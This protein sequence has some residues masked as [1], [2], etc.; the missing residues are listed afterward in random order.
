MERAVSPSTDVKFVS[1]VFYWMVVN[2]CWEERVNPPVYV[3]TQ[4]EMSFAL[5]GDPRV[6]FLSSQYSMTLVLLQC[7]FFTLSETVNQ[8]P[9]FLPFYPTK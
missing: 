9:S 5:R 6:F 8:M 4:C 3:A 7:R 1:N 2:R